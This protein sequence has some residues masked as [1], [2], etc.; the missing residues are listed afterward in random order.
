MTT[1]SKTAAEVWGAIYIPARAFNAP[2]FW[3]NY[4]PDEA[5]RDMG[6]AASVNLNA[7]RV[8]VSYEFWKMAPNDFAGVFDDFLKKAAAKRIRLMPSL[9]ENC[10]VDPT[11]ENMWTTGPTKA[12]AIRSPHKADIVDNPKRW[13]GPARFVEW[14]LDRYGSDRRLLAIELMN[15]P[16][17]EESKRFARAMIARANE[18]RGSVPLTLGAASADMNLY[19]LDC[20]IDVFQV[21]ENFPKDEEAMRQKVGDALRAGR[22]CGKRVWL[23][24]WQ[25]L[26]PTTGGWKRGDRLPEK[27]LGPDLASVAGIVRSFGMD[28]FFW[29]LMVKPA[30][31]PG[32]RHNGTINGLFWEDGAVW[33]Q[34]DAR[35]VA[36]D[37]KLKFEERRG[38]PEWGPP[39]AWRG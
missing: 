13:G 32:Q 18:L 38:W 31:L 37:K 7:L 29:S 1:S 22:V 17:P 21:H 33:S 23:T 4:D 30:Y 8:W 19:F 10:G 5:K 3:R 11:K 24:E 36:G 34:A 6:Y 20:G 39:K 27:E 26:R 9:F 28:A 2:Q 12:F 14:F 35:A 15:E 25:R 16:F